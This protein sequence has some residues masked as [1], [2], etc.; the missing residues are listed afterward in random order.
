MDAGADRYMIKTTL[1]TPPPTGALPPT[2]RLG[3]PPRSYAD[4]PTDARADS[5]ESTQTSMTMRLA[6]IFRLASRSVV[7]VDGICADAGERKRLERGPRA[8]RDQL[9]GAEI[10]YINRKPFFSRVQTV[11]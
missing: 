6:D 2:P 11:V 4:G 1:P 5:T 9:R 8:R 10:D 7:G 3:E